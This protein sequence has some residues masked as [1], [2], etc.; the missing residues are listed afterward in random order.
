MTIE[1]PAALVKIRLALI[2][3]E[4]ALQEAIYVSEQ[5]VLN[6]RLQGGVQVSPAPLAPLPMAAL[7]AQAA[8][9][10]ANSTDAGLPAALKIN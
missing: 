8:A 5:R 1:D 10:A 2:N 7:A 9:T 6:A 4:R 3:K